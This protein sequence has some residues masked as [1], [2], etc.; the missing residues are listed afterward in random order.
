MQI[1]FKEMFKKLIQRKPKKTKISD[2]LLKV[3]D[4]IGKPIRNLSESSTIKL[5][6]EELGHKIQDLEK[7]IEGTGSFDLKRVKEIIFLLKNK[8]MTALDVGKMLKLSRNRTS[9]Y[10][11]KMEVEDILESRV[12]GKKKYYQIAKG[13]TK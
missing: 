8:E 7:K 9:E 1:L 11:K 2:D 3:K 6:L 10:L 5:Q 4:L 13:K 12:V